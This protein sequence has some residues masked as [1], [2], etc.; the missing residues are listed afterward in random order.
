M[1]YEDRFSK[2]HTYTHTLIDSIHPYYIRAQSNFN[3][4]LLLI[5]FS[6]FSSGPISATL[7]IPSKIGL[8]D[9]L[10]DETINSLKKVYKKKPN[11]KNRID[12]HL[13]TGPSGSLNET[14]L[15]TPT[16]FHMNVARFFAR[17]EFIFFLDFDTWPTPE[18]HSNIKRYTDILI[19]N[20]VL[21][22]PTFV[23]IENENSEN[24]TTKRKFPETKDD[25]VD[26]L[27]QRRL[28]LQDY[29]WE[30]NSGPT[31]LD[32][33]LKAIK[34]FRVQEYELHYRPNFI[35]RKSRQ[36]PW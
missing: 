32:N 29:G 33:W 14:L 5:Y 4:F 21:I 16:N 23:F 13:I 8:T 1:T 25:V 3:Q 31:C 36:I 30:I 24:S 2:I 12:I 35:V 6:I 9:P 27:N 18:T 28:G 20:N 7:H 34:L 17:T 19:K 15:P 10:I 26:L 22:L 11:L